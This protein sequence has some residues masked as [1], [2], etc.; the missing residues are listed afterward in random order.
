MVYP[1]NMTMALDSG[2]NCLYLSV[3]GPPPLKLSDIQ[4][5]VYL[6]NLIS[7]YVSVDNPVKFRDQLYKYLL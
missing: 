6:W 4:A 3:K 7:E 1:T 5:Y 2:A